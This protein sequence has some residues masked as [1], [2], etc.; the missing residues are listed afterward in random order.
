MKIRTIEQLSDILAED[1]A[2]RKKELSEVKSLIE[3][4]DISE[5]KYKLFLRSGICILYAHWE[6]FVKLASNSYLE[7]VRM[8]KLSYDQLASNF[9]ALAMKEKLKETKDTNKPSLYIPICDFFL[10]ELNQKSN[11]P[12]EAISTAS[13]L[14]SEILKEIMSILG[15]NFA[16]YSTKSK[17]IDEKLLK[18]RNEIAHG[19]YLLIDREEYLELHIEIINLLNIFK[20]QIENAC[21][22]EKYKRY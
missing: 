7:F 14:S 19:S 11:L 13:N 17:L 15:L 21:L 2:W 5:Q 6:G 10:F 1:L 22:Q 3:L 16:D 18:S 12:K 20:N 4:K 9:V 8:Q